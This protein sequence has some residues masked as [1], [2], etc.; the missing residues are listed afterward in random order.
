MREESKRQESIMDKFS[1][2]SIIIKCQAHE[3]KDI[4]TVFEMSFINGSMNRYIRDELGFSNLKIIF[5]SCLSYKN[6]TNLYPKKIILYS[7]QIAKHYDKKIYDLNLNDN[8]NIPN[9][10]NAKYIELPMAF[11]TTND[12]NCIKNSLHNKISPIISPVN[13]TILH[14]LSL[15]D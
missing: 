7:K 8:P 5:A 10:L 1:Y 3:M 6:Y 15:R 13:Q 2:I 9:I 11:P 12:V 4:K 14:Y